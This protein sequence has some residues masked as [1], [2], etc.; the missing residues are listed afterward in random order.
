M[1]TMN[2]KVII[3]P[4]IFL[5]SSAGTSSSVQHTL[6]V[7]VIN[8]ND[9]SPVFELKENGVI[10]IEQEENNSF[11]TKLDA[12]DVENDPLTWSI[13]GERMLLSFL[14]LPS[15]I[16][17]SWVTLIMNS[18]ILQ[19]EIIIILSVYRFQTAILQS[20]IVLLLKY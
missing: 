13:T 19:L 12:T 16:L 4:E 7:E 3:E 17:A 11:I 15:E 5:D 18:Q 2:T 6:V 8:E 9:N 1:E 20:I 14:F 10:E